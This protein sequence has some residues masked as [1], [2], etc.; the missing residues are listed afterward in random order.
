MSEERPNNSILVKRLLLTVAR[1]VCV[2][3]RTSAVV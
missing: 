2:W 1:N 3:V